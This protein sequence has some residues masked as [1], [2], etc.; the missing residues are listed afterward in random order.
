[1]M[2]L[3]ALAL[4]LVS[5]VAG[6]LVI[7]GGVVG[8]CVVLDLGPCS[9]Q[10]TAPLL[11]PHRAVAEGDFRLVLPSPDGARYAAVPLYAPEDG[12]I[13]LVGRDGT[14]ETPRWARHVE[15]LRGLAWMPDSSALLVVFRREPDAAPASDR[16]GI[17]SLETGSL[18][19]KFELPFPTVDFGGIAVSPDGRSALIAPDP[20]AEEGEHEPLYRIDLADGRAE[21]IDVEGSFGS[22]LF[23]DSRHVAAVEHRTG[24]AG[25]SLVDLD[26]GTV[27]LLTPS[28]LNVSEIAG[29]AIG[30]GIVFSAYRVLT[31]DPNVMLSE[32][33]DHA[34]VAVVNSETGETQELFDPD[35]TR[36]LR[37]L[38]DGDRAVALGDACADGSTWW[39]PF[40]ECLSGGEIWELDLRGVLD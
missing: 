25:L 38:P 20:F 1:M 8:A 26:T 15:E 10:P 36:R 9:P 33:F 39:F 27:E 7:A 4:L 16:I 35:P 32:E 21:A 17:L 28:D 18:E 31:P 11:P 5:S 24:F 40:A 19:V 22:L 23:I 6:A 34:V 12:W 3:R 30:G 14:I 13:G 37:M 2:R 29:R